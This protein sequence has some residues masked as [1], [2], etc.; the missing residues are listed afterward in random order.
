MVYQFWS[1]GD[2][3]RPPGAEDAGQALP[4]Y[5][6]VSELLIRDMAAGR[7]PDGTRLAPERRLA[8][9]LGVAV[10]TLRKALALMERKGLLE[11]VQGSGNY[12]RHAPVIDSVYALFRLELPEGAGLPRAELL[13]LEP[14]EKPADLPPF[15]ASQEAT[16]IRRRRYLNDVLVALEEIFL[17]ASA[18]T[19]ERADLSESLYASYRAALGLHIVAMEDRVGVAPVPAWADGLFSMAPGCPAGFVERTASAD[20]G[21]PVE[22]SRTWFDPDRA[23]YVQRLR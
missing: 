9:D 12:V 16:R 10:G 18:G 13:G 5:V 2:A 21:A 20:K 6:Q 23:R 15:G 19:L 11:R 4:L 22:Y 17:D 14:I 1:G 7:L 8:A 3:Q